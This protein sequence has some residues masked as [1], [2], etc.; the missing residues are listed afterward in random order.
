MKRFLTPQEKKVLR[1]TKDRRNAYAEARAVSRKAIAK[2]KALS[3]RSLR[4]AENAAATKAVAGGA[5]AD[6]VVRPTKKNSWRKIP[7]VPLANFVGR[8]LQF[9]FLKGTNL[10]HQA[11]VLL[12]KAR[13]NVEPRPKSYKGPLQ[14]DL[15]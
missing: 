14:H 4:H 15:D 6:P 1:Y 8:R 3:S 13:R 10:S 7:D 11:S 5:N 9:R 2:R 12:R